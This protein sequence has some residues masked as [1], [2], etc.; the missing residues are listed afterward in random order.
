MN[1]KYKGI[2]TGV[3]ERAYREIAV[4]LVPCSRKGMKLCEKHL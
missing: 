2:G 4:P 3:Y 1:L